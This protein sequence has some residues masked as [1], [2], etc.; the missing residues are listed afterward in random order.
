M[1]GVASPYIIICARPTPHD[2]HCID[3]CRCSWRQMTDPA[4]LASAPQ[5]GAVMLADA[6][7]PAIFALS[8]LRGSSSPS[9]PLRTLPAAWARG[10][11]PAL[12]TLA[13]LLTV[14][15]RPSASPR[16]R[17]RNARSRQWCASRARSRGLRRLREGTWTWCNRARQGWDSKAGRREQI[18]GG[19]SGHRHS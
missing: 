6:S 12:A 5:P 17:A 1:T 15:A 16:A 14:L 7:A 13:S 9:A 3:I 18:H 4:V 11:V 19:S 10:Y 8:L 2:R